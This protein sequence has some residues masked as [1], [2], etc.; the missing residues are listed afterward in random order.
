MCVRER[1]ESA[2]ESVD[3]TDLKVEKHL[4][5]SQMGSEVDSGKKAKNIYPLLIYLGEDSRS[6][7]SCSLGLVKVL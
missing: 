1:P 3:L 6:G 4:S 2:I 7:A 5:R